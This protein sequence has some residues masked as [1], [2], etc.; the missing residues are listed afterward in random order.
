MNPQIKQEIKDLVGNLVENASVPEE[1]L[2]FEEYVKTLHNILLTV[3]DLDEESKSELNRAAGLIVAKSKF[4]R[5]KGVDKNLVIRYV[6]IPFQKLE[7]IMK[8]M[9]PITEIKEEFKAVRKQGPAG[10]FMKRK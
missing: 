6:D 3:D 4:L 7:K 10:P 1:L 2:S 5:S 9:P 8:E